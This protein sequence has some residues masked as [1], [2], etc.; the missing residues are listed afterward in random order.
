MTPGIPSRAL[1]PVD[2]RP[3]E[4]YAGIPGTDTGGATEAVPWEG[5][6]PHTDG[7]NA[8]AETRGLPAFP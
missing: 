1:G 8:G 3:S 4:W 6:Q 7:P 5:A 2:I